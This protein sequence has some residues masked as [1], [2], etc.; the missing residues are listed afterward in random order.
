M[1]GDAS[2]SYHDLLAMTAPELAGI[3]IALMNLLC[4]RGLP[5]CGIGTVG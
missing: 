3:D 4:A 5:A 2:R 1:E